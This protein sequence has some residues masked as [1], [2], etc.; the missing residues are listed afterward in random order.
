M[1]ATTQKQH[2]QMAKQFNQAELEQRQQQARTKVMEG[3]YQPSDYG[4]GRWIYPAQEVHTFTG[5]EPAIQFVAE[6]ASKGR[7]LYEYDSPVCQGNFFSVSFYKSDEELEQ[8]FKASD[9]QVEAEYQTEINQHN[10]EQ[11][12]VLQ[13]QLVSAEIAKEQKKEEQRVAAIREKALKTAQDH[14]NSQLA[15]SN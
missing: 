14:I 2:V 7:K 12:R 10:A 6:M 15:G 3:Y 8:L 5:F 13:E 4:S 11:V 1:N 9:A